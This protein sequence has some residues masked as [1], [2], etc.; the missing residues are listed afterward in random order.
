MGKELIFV[1]GTL[2]KNTAAPM[3]T[4][5]I[6]HCSYHGSGILKGKLYEV[7]GYPGAILSANPAD[8]VLGEL[9]AI[10]DEKVLAMLDTYEECTA[11]FPTPHEYIRSICPISQPD[12]QEVNAWVYLYN[13]DISTL[14]PILSGDYMDF[15]ETDIH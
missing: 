14:S 15:L 2:R 3:H 5:L 10:N 6:E 13:H 9:Y 1:Y 4:I 7:D 8:K 11:L 12:M